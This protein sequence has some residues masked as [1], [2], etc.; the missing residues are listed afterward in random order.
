MMVHRYVQK[1][2]NTG[3]TYIG[4]HNTNFKRLQSGY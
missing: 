3:L 1:L 2:N 4:K